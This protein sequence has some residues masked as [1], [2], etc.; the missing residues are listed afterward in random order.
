LPSFFQK[1]SVIGT[2]LI[3]DSEVFCCVFV[4]P[5]STLFC[6]DGKEYPKKENENNNADN[7]DVGH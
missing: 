3:T 7:D 6:L 1:K 2:G 5:L 4:R